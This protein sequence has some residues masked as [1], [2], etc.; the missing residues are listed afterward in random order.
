M[1]PKFRNS[2]I[3]MRQVIITSI[4]KDLTRKPFFGRGWSWFKFNKL[5]ET[6]G[7]ALKLYTS[8]AKR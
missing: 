7:M 5:G 4:Y 3:S 6:L 8:V 1:R 2:N